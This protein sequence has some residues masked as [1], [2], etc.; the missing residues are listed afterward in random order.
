M[1]AVA[2]SMISGVCFV[3][4]LTLLSMNLSMN[5]HIVRW[6]CVH[7]RNVPHTGTSSRQY[8]DPSL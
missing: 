5:H 1:Q 3:N 2:P 8:L 4:G 6:A 7:C